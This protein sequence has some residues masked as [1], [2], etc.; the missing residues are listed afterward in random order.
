[1]RYEQLVAEPSAAAVPVADALGVDVELVA[2]RF[3]RVHDRSAGR[4]RRDLT[5]DQLADVERE[6][7]P[8]LTALGYTP[9]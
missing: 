2:A 6:A 3:A 9:A 4:W 8:A 1:M 7:G 5:A